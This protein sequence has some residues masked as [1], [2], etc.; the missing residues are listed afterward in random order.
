MV[1][2]RREPQWFLKVKDNRE[3]VVVVVQLGGQH[4]AICIRWGNLCVCVCK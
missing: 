1:E 4:F 2:L 3:V